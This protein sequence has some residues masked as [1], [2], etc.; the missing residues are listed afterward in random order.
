MNSVRAFAASCLAVL[1]AGAMHSK[2]DTRPDSLSRPAAPPKLLFT[3]G[4]AGGRS[5]YLYDIQTRN[6]TELKGGAGVDIVDAGW[7]S[8]SDSIIYSMKTGDRIQSF[9][10]DSR[11]GVR[12]SYPLESGGSYKSSPDGRKLLIDKYNYPP[13]DAGLY[14]S[15]PVG[16]ELKKIAD[17]KDGR[18]SPG[19]RMILYVRASGSKTQLC[20]YDISGETSKTVASFDALGGFGWAANEDEIYYSANVK[21]DH[22]RVYRIPAIGGD[23]V[24]VTHGDVDTA[25]SLSP[26]GA[27][28]AYLKFRG[29]TRFLNFTEIAILDIAAGSVRVVPFH[30]ISRDPRAALG[31]GVRSIAWSPDAKWIAFTWSPNVCTPG[32]EDSLAILE[33]STGVVSP[34]A[35]DIKNERFESV[36]VFAWK[37]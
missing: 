36:G 37:N 27:Q 20:T 30:T 6:T 14:F 8:G 29:E 23:S 25:P 16:K 22:W 26:T 34:I 28:L 13:P 2:T 31:A 7:I 9:R 35:G 32:A 18:W 11:D 33:V 4:A 17:G 24:E 5:L 21:D 12:A 10:E 19:G 15:T 1:P 3:K